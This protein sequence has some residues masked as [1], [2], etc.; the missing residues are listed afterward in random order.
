MASLHQAE[1]VARFHRVGR[2]LYQRAGDQPSETDDVL[3]GMMNSPAL[4]DQV[5]AFLN[6][7]TIDANHKHRLTQD[8]WCCDL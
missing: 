3:I 5:I 8:G 7:S 1:A 2:I 4:A 6:R